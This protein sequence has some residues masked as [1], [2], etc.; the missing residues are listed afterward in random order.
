MRSDFSSEF[1]TQTYIIHT[2]GIRLKDSIF[3]KNGPAS[4]SARTER[5]ILVCGG[6]GA[7][8]RL[9]TCLHLLAVRR[10]AQQTALLGT[11]HR[12]LAQKR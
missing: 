6:G 4:I 10:R 1:A 12:V 3:W 9:F 11:D 2:P 8:T 5:G 7:L